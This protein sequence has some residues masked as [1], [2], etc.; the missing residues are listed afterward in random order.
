MGRTASNLAAGCRNGSVR[1]NHFRNCLGGLP[2]SG[3][4]IASL[5]FAFGF[6]I[7][8]FLNY[9]FRDSPVYEYRWV[10]NDNKEMVEQKTKEYI[11]NNL[12]SQWRAGTLP[13]EPIAAHLDK[14][15]QSFEGE[16]SGHSVKVKAGTSYSDSWVICAWLVAG[17]VLV[18][19]INLFFNSQFYF[20][21]CRYWDAR[22]EMKRALTKEQVRI[23]KEFSQKYPEILK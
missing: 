8:T 6:G 16:T 14:I 2:M 9:A 4:S 1:G 22:I 12:Y 13:D 19:L 17:S 18:L 23:F 11:S 5:I 21:M 10:A 3:T 15:K 7:L 20:R